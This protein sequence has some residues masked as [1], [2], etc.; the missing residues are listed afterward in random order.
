MRIVVGLGNPGR[1]Y[2]QTRHN[3][4]FMVVDELARRGAAEGPRKKFRAEL[5]E[6]VL[7]G[8]K[9]VLLKPQ[10]FMNLSGRSVREAVAWYRLPAEDLLVV[11]DDLD[12]PFG[13]L[14]LRARGTAGGHNGVASVVASLGTTEVPRLK[15]GIGRGRADPES[16]VLARFSPEQ[17]RELPD[18]IVQAAD[19]V[20][21]WLA[22]GI[23]ASMNR[24]NRRV[25][26][27]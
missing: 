26:V 4:G 17:E 19:A 18:L 3:V 24:V 5:F 16:Y 27:A 22:E 23:V 13:G 11:Q 8:Q 7:A 2:A 14:R 15:I 1:E 20:E 25:E 10:T 12:L 9:V 21:L 6:G